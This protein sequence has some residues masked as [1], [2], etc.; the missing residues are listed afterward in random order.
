[1]SPP[2]RGMER[3]LTGVRVAVAIDEQQHSADCN[4]FLESYGPP[5][6]WHGRLWGFAPAAILKKGAKLTLTL[7][8]GA[9]GEVIILRAGVRGSYD[10]QGEGMP[11]TF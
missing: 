4:L 3:Q 5:P 7:P 8:K 2:Q 11:P 6:R 1:M 10:F 9:T